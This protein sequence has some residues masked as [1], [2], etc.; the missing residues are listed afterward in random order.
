MFACKSVISTTQTQTPE[1]NSNLVFE[2][3]ITQ[4]YYLKRFTK[5][6]EKVFINEHAKEIFL[7]HLNIHRHY[8]TQCRSN[9]IGIALWL[10][11]IVYPISEQV[12]WT[13]I[14]HMVKNMISAV[15]DMNSI[16]NWFTGT[17]QKN[18]NTWL[19]ILESAFTLFMQFFKGLM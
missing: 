2:V 16:H 17:T 18:S 8:E 6:S 9:Q 3:C 12:F 13:Y 1:E 10:C 11:M 14:F 15:Y 4:R 19:K 5:I 7:L